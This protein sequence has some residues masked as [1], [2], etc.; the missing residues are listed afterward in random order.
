MVGGLL[1]GLLET[2]VAGYISS[3]YKDMVA[4]MVLLIFLFIKPT[5]IFNETAIIRQ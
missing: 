1:L 3:M 5:G 4:F 2:F